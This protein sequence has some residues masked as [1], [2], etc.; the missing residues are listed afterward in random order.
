MAAVATVTERYGIGGTATLYVGTVAFDSS[1][2]TGGEAIDLAGNE[3]V[4][5][6]LCSHEDG[7]SFLWDRAN[8]KLLVYYVDNNA[9]GDSAQIQ[10]PDTT[11]IS[12]ITACPFI[13]IGS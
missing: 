8:Q 5:I 7:Y 12:S 9:A 4:D 6:M 2:P 13:A 1:Y 3:S 10:V 11:D